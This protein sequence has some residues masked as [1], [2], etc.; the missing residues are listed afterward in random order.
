VNNGWFAKLCRRAKDRRLKASLKSAASPS[1]I[2][3]G[4]TGVAMEVAVTTDEFRVSQ[5]R[6]H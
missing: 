4:P 2:V 3:V 6:Y 1:T 5:F